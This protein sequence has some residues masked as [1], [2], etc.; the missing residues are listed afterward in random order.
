MWND[1]NWILVQYCH[2]R[3]T[4]YHIYIKLHTLTIVTS[5]YLLQKILLTDFSDPLIIKASVLCEWNDRKGFWKFSIKCLQD[6]DLL[7]EL[8]SEIKTKKDVWTA[9]DAG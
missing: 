8:K 6:P 5:L 4:L 3:K 1:N 2:P 7:N 9:R